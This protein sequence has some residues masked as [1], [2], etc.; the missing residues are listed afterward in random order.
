MN[1]DPLLPSRAM[2]KQ[3]S[4]S[5]EKWHTAAII[6]TEKYD[7]VL[8]STELCSYS[9]ASCLNIRQHEIS[10]GN[11]LSRSYYNGVSVTVS[12][13]WPPVYFVAV[14]GARALSVLYLY[15]TEQFAYKKG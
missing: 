1:I 3:Q 6:M 8:Y 11:Y 13:R 12:L 5:I 10:R 7:L 9:M 14:P 4:F 2:N 15:C